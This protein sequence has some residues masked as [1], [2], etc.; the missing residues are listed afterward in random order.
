VQG[1]S[2]QLSPQTPNKHLR[3]SS[4][5]RAQ[6]VDLFQRLSQLLGTPFAV[7][8]FQLWKTETY[9]GVGGY[10]PK[11]LFAE[12]YSVSQKVDP[13]EFKIYHIKGTYTS[14]RRF[15]QKGVIWMFR[16]MIKSYL[17]RNNP[18]FFTHHHNY[19]N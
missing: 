16:I 15:K 10:N 5:T 18:D 3:R 14:A 1:R 19:W 9:W 4:Q 7:G 13:Q 12:D 6:A 17:Q 2:H 8:G 11:E